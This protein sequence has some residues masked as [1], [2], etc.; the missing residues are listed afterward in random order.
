MN[1]T[2]Y[3]SQLQSQGIQDSDLFLISDRHVVMPYRIISK[4]L[5]PPECIFCTELV[6]SSVQ[7]MYALNTTTDMFNAHDMGK[8]LWWHFLIRTHLTKN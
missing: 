1:L 4:T 3:E 7:Y 5:L 8:I 2:Q 6:C